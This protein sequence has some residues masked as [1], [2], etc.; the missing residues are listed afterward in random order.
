M[1]KGTVLYIASGKIIDYMELFLLWVKSAECFL[2]IMKI[3][4]FVTRCEF[5]LGW[6]SD[7]PLRRL[8]LRG[9][10]SRGFSTVFAPPWPS[11]VMALLQSSN[12]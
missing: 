8:R 5:E 3:W 10:D 9:R 6:E 7:L 12:S 1:L 4:S 2:V 11:G